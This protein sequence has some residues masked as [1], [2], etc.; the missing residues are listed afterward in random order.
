MPFRDQPRKALAAFGGVGVLGASLPTGVLWFELQQ[1]RAE[2]S[3]AREAL[4]VQARVLAG[5]EVTGAHDEANRRLT[6]LQASVAGMEGRVRTNYEL[7]QWL[8]QREHPKRVP[9]L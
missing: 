8:I 1:M 7:L 5:H 3:K 4:G 9:P 6:A 2:V